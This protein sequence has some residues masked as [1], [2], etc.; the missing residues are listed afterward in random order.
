MSDS[1]TSKI[2]GTNKENSLDL[3]AHS[4]NR[5]FGR[6]GS[7][8]LIGL[9]NLGNTCFMNSSIQCL[10]HTPK[11]VDYFLGDYTRNINRTNPL[12]LN[13]ELALA[14]GELLRSLWTTDRKPV[15]PH[16]FKEKIACFAPQFS[17]F[18]QHDSQELLAFLLDG[19]H[20][21]L[22]QVK[23]KPYEEAKDASGRPDEEVADEYWSNHLARND[24]V[25]VDTCHGQYKS[26]LTCPTCSKRSVTFDPFMYLSLPVPSTAK[27]AM[28]VTVFSTDGSRE[29]CSYDVNVPKFGTLSDLVQALSIACLLG[30]DEILLVAEVYNNC[31]L[32][33]L[34]EP[35][36]SVSLLRDGDKLA[37]YRL[38]KKYE[39]SPLV[40]FTHQ[41]FD[42]HS[43]GDNLTPQKKEFEA[44]LLAVLPERVN[45]LSLQNIYLKLLN[46]FQ[47]SR[48]ASSLNGSAGSNV[49]S[50]DLMD[51]T[52]SDSGSNFQ[53]IQLEDDPGSSNCSTNE[54]EITNAPDEL[55]DGGAADPNKERRVEDFEFYL[56]N[57][58]GDVQ[59]QK[60]EINELDLLETIPNRLHVNVHWQQNASIQYAASMLNS[61]PE[62][63]KL[64]LTPKG[65]EDSVALH[66]CLEA[67]LKEEPL[68]P[69]DMWYC[70]CCKKH[71]Q[72]MKKLDLWRLPEVLVIHL[73]RFSYTQFTRNKLETFVDFPTTDLDLSSYIADKSKQPSSHYRLYAIS[74]HY[75]N[76]GGGHYTASIYHEEG[77]GWYKFDDDC[78]TPIGENSIKT[79]AAYVLF[80]RRQ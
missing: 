41:H 29:P 60:I 30:D 11:L 22:N 7:M 14:F 65:T 5:S 68:G 4:Y 12:G 35:S 48:R 19:L 52:P 50:A 2:G 3:D 49:D 46:P 77:K 57:E 51:G 63:N 80:Y 39:K 72:A 78:V 15:A 42:E 75:G 33:Y 24:S 58:R 45:G 26:T 17:G 16:N 6:A 37:A 8:G 71:Q 38:P 73:K 27:R 61:L 74:N 32:R 54:C 55:Y 31:I 66:G 18:N 53:D 47:L 10:A 67:F 28:T 13:G 69:E 20:E 64:E 79:P 34:E 36:D 56:R 9:E 76:M 25:I 59:Q 21:D 23:C 44:P 62:I 43:S 40:I 1:L 70:P